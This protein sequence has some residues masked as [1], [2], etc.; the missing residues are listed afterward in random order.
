M[1]TSDAL[2]SDRQPAQEE[3]GEGEILADL[4]QL[5]Q[6][7]GFI[8]TFCMMVW[9]ALWMT[10]EEVPDIDWHGRPNNKELSLLLGFLAK[11][12]LELEYVPIRE[13]A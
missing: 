12:P 7:P 3:R 5:T 11:R 4:D 6:E 13:K 2:P 10:T 9:H 8:Y 1:S